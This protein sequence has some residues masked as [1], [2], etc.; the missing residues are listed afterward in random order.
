VVKGLS[1]RSEI[2][3]EIACGDGKMAGLARKEVRRPTKQA[4]AWGRSGP[5]AGG[6]RQ[7]DASGRP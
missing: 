6:K 4:S 1:G 5:I 2:S 3:V 7:S